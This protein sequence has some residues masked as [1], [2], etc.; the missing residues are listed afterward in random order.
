MNDISIIILVGGGVFS[1]L[2]AIIGFFLR[3]IYNRLEMSQT[4]KGCEANM[5][6]CSSLRSQER[7]YAGLRRQTDRDKIDDL[8]DS[9]DSLC[10]CLKDYTKGVCP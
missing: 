6:H 5:M 2:L 8:V 4:V 9:F 7:E 3:G 1:I 10:R